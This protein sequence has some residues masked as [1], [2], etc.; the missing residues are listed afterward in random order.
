[1][2]AQVR[3]QGVEM[4]KGTKRIYLILYLSIISSSSF[5]PIIKLIL[6][7]ADRREVGDV[8]YGVRGGVQQS[9]TWLGR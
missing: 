6:R 2:L 4:R 1:V 3:N 9:L 7:G 8:R 5:C